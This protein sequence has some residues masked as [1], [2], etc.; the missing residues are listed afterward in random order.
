M[1][2]KTTIITTKMRMWW[3]DGDDGDNNV[4]GN[5]DGE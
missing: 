4:D 1:F 5:N 3:D 2:D